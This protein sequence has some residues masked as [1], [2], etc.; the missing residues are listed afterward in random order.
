MQ[1]HIDRKMYHVEIL[2]PKQK[3]PKLEESLEKFAVKFRK[4]IEAGYVVCIPDN[5]MGNLAFQGTELIQELGVPVRDGQVSIHINTFHTKADLDW[6]LNTAVELGIDHLLSISGD[7]SPRLPKLT[8]KDV[9]YDVESVTSVELLKYIHREYPG[10]FHIGVAFNPYEPQDH[11]MEKMQRKVDAGAEFVTTQPVIE[12]H[13]AMEPLRKF[14]LPIVV[15]AW[16]SKK[17]HL[18]SECVGYEIPEDT[19]Y[20]PM[21]NLKTLISNY[22]DCGFYLALTGFKSQFPY[23]GDLWN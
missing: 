6:I 14:G 23:I 7:G 20:D 12:T 16:M 1:Y 13:P 3:S 8:G 2:S 9:G 18:L 10:K 5:P 4:I 15:E 22:P 17:L 21:E 11:E 19:L